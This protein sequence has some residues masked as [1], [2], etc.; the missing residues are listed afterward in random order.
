[1]L[2]QGASPVRKAAYTWVGI[3]SRSSG[4]CPA[5]Q[6]PLLPSSRMLDCARTRLSSSFAR[7]SWPSAGQARLC[8]TARGMHV[9]PSCYDG[10]IDLDRPCSWSHYASREIRLHSRHGLRCVP[11]VGVHG[12]RIAHPRPLRMTHH[13]EQCCKICGFCIAFHPPCCRYTRLLLVDEG[14]MF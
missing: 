6:H 2:I 14:L 5:Y 1:M 9:T 11:C 10:L 12:M 7:I 8:Q 4:G 3:Q 13:P